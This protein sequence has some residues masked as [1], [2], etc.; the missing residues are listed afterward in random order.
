[1]AIYRKINPKLLSDRSALI[2]VVPNLPVKYVP[3]RKFKPKDIDVF[4]K[5]GRTAK[6]VVKKGIKFGVAAGAL[7]GVG[8]LAS[9]PSREYNMGP[10]T[11]EPRDLRSPVIYRGLEDFE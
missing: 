5:A 11:Y 10:K 2:D 4:T 6:S 7:A 8:Y 3:P 1:M 9:E